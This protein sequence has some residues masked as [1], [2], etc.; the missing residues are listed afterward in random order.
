MDAGHEMIR[1]DSSVVVLNTFLNRV[2]EF[3]ALNYLVH[4]QWTECLVLHI[5]SLELSWIVTSIR[6]WL[7]WRCLC[8]KMC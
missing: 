5:S 3:T 7:P 6:M 8:P 2:T 4:F 1:V